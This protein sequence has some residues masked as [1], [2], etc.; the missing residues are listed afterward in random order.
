MKAFIT[1]SEWREMS[2]PNIISSMDTAVEVLLKRKVD[3]EW[4]KLLL[5][6][7]SRIMLK[8]SEEW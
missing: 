4:M 5:D 1:A 3:R 8:C 7:A 2:T 6:I